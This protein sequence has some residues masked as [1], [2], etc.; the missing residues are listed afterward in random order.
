MIIDCIADLHGYH[1]NLEGGDL[2]ILSGDYTARDT[3]PQW[4]EFFGWLKKQNYR[5]KIIVA[6]NHDNF[7][8]HGFPK[9]KEEADN[10]KEINEFLDED[11]PDF[12]YLC[13]S[14]T[15][16]EG[17]KIWGTPHSLIFDGVNPHCT[18]FIGTE[19]ELQ[20]KYD[21]ITDGIDILISHTPPYGILD[22]NISG[23]WCGSESLRNAM[24]R[25]KPK[26]LICGHIHECGGKE[27]DLTTTSVVNCSYVNERY[28]PTNK[29]F[30]IVI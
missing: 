27:V 9:T 22:K 2:L 4:A 14:G 25:T 30:R 1:P 19:E 6:G 29:P 24:F 3:I 11:S 10:C 5:K 21:L 18:A 8:C 28:K 13:N 20:E 17:L 16:F 12:E 7:M 15:E 26:Y 23:E